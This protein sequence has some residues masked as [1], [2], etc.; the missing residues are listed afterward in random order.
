MAILADRICRRSTAVHDARWSAVGTFIA[1]AGVVWAVRPVL[2]LS[3]SFP[4]KAI[5]IFTLGA[6]F[7]V[8][9][10]ERYLAYGS[11]GPANRVTLARGALIALLLALIGES[12]T[13]ARAWFAV[14]V[15]SLAVAM[16]GF[17]GWLARRRGS[18]SDFGARFDMETDAVLIFA[19]AA[20]AWQY[21]KAGS[22]ILAAGLLRYLF[23]ASA[24][25]IPWM[26]RALPKS[27]RRQ[28]ICVF[29]ALSL[30]VCLA[31]ALPPAVSYFVA[32]AG[33]ALLCGSFAV[34]IVWLARA[35]GGPLQDSG[36]T[37]LS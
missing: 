18:S 26:R 27:R 30:V 11:F 3:R 15:A 35:P 13:T 5:L 31:P 19:T 25:L 20:L 14:M 10:A 34:D 17:D 24:Y 1:T 16:D 7:V 2:E 36:G 9:L 29:Q 8:A 21:G 22:W 6:T 32:M 37:R 33:L 12:P 28:T 4:L 23:A